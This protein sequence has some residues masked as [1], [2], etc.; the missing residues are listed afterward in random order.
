MGFLDFWKNI[1]KKNKQVKTGISFGTPL[2]TS[3]YGNDVY[4]SDIVLA[5]IHAIAEE[6]SKMIL[7]SVKINKENNSVTENKDDLNRLFH[8]KPNSLMTMKDLIYWISWRLEVDSNAYIYPEIEVVTYSDGTKIERVSALYPVDTISETMTYD[9]NLGEYKIIFCL[10]DGN[11]YEVPYSQVIHLR[12]HFESNQI[13]FAKTDRSELLKTLKSLDKIQE[14]TPKAVQAS[15]QTKGILHAKSLA[16]VNGLKEFKKTFEQ[17]AASG[18]S[19]IAVLDVA[20]EFTPVNIN[21]QV[22]DPATLSFLESKILKN[23]G[24]PLN[25]I[26][27]NATE[28]EWASFYQK[29][30]EPFK[31][32]LEQA[33]NAV[34][35]SSD[36][37]NFGN[38]I[39]CYDRLVQHYS[40]ATRLAIVKELGSRNYLSR[41][42]QREMLGF[43]PDGGPEKVSLNFVDQDKANQYQGV[44]GKGDG[45]DEGKDS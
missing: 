36:K 25:I 11:Q 2:W 37:R 39:R 5:C 14:M 35:L 19:S 18:D 15:M 40:I 24:V 30:I 26:L 45:E 23:F 9:E 29:N 20:G 44:S 31:I 34:L 21:P 12:K 17:T 13:F 4:V 32:E 16:D 10:R 6:S 8:S 38:E 22:V 3:T 28:S 42:E 33:M 7:K 43:E 1:F 41:S 27:G